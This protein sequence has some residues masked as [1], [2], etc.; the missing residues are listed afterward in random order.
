MNFLSIL[1]Y[2]KTLDNFNKFHPVICIGGHEI[3]EEYY[4]YY[5]IDGIVY[6]LGISATDTGSGGYKNLNLS[7]S[8]PGKCNPCSAGR[9]ECNHD[10]SSPGHF[11]H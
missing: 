10:D 1:K 2:L 4:D 7:K 9:K 6:V 3:F 5:I 8:D 11:C